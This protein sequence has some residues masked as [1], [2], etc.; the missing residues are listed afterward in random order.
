MTCVCGAQFDTYP[1]QTR[2][3]RGKF[4]SKAC[5]YANATR[6]SGLRY[7]IKVIN[8]AWIKP[9]TVMPKEAAS[10]GWRGDQVGY[11]RLHR[12]I[13]L[14]R[15]TPTEC[16]HCGTTEGLIEWANKSHEYRRDLT[17]WLSLCRRCHRRHDRG[18]RGVATAKYGAGNLAGYAR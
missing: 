8:R 14:H 16:E 5:Q 10:P 2:T 3:G 12:W 9:G 13:R 6:P 17:D 15:G 18:F 1:S 4:C 7:E 11:Q